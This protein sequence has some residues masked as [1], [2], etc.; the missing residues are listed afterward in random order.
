M[1]VGIHIISRNI[2]HRIK[3][4]RVDLLYQSG[5][6]IFEAIPKPVY[7]DPHGRKYVYDYHT[8]REK[9]S[10]TQQLEDVLKAD[11]IL[12]KMLTGR[13]VFKND[14]YLGLKDR[15]G[16]FYRFKRLESLEEWERSKWVL[17]R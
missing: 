16:N 11:I 3:L 15:K 1:V 4:R 9:R 14:K 6:P 13:L 12:P 17:S 10:P 5:F 8:T 7:E 2:I